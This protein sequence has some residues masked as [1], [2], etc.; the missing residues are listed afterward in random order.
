MQRYSRDGLEIS[1]R[2]FKND[3]ALYLAII[4]T[5][6]SLDGN[7]A[8]THSLKIDLERVL[9]DTLASPRV[10]MKILHPP[11]YDLEVRP[12][13]MPQPVGARIVVDIK[14]GSVTL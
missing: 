14:V 7:C 4:R 11:S 13:E 12:S 2:A 10:V 5:T 6:E 8:P 1:S 9:K 3:D